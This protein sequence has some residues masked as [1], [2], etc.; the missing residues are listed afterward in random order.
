[1][2]NLVMETTGAIVD[3]LRQIWLKIVDIVPSLIAAIV[4]L[5]VG[6]FVGVIL[7]HAVKVLL[8]KLKFDEYVKK[9]KLTKAARR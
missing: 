5:I 8:D 2:A 6:A 9:A 4:V 1:M 7:G 3:P